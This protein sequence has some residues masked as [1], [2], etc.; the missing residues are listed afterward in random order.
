[1]EPVEG[2]ARHHL[3]DG[4]RDT[5]TRDI[6]SCDIETSDSDIETSDSDI[7]TSDSDIETSDI[8]TD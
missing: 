7:E 8:D 1:M 2:S 4:A 3:D 5:R 6:D